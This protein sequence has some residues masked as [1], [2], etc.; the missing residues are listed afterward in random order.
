ME[1]KEFILNDADFEKKKTE[2]LVKRE[3]FRQITI[4]SFRADVILELKRNAGK[5]YPG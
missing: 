1:I 2:I 3:L 4:F 5:W